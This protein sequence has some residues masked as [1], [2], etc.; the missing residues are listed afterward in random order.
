MRLM[1]TFALLASV[2]AFPAFAQQG[3]SSAKKD[4]DVSVGMAYGIAPSYEGSG[5]YSNMLLPLVNIKWKETIGLDAGGLKWYA[6]KA[7]PLTGGIGLTYDAGRDERTGSLPWSDNSDN[8]L[9]GMGDVDGSPGVRLFA[10]YD[11]QPIV[12]DGSITQYFGRG[13]VDGFIASAELSWPYQVN[14]QLRIKPLIN[15]TWGSEDYNSVYF[16]VSPAQ[17]I[18]TGFPVY[19]ASSGFKDASAGVNAIYFVDPHWYVMGDAR[20]KQLLGDV[21]DSPVTKQ[22]TSGQ[23]VTGVGY[24]F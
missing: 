17:S 15:T 13:D 10:S 6:L 5:H 8:R 2:F 9:I 3:E 7:G 14:Q 24:K 12:L 18:A 23:F 22:D 1:S 11:F 19:N 21:A 16:D 20:V 4:W